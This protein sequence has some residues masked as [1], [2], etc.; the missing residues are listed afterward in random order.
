MR[1]LKKSFTLPTLNVLNSPD[2]GK[3]HEFD[4]VTFLARTVVVRFTGAFLLTAVALVTGFLADGFLVA[5]FPLVIAY[6]IAKCN[7]FSKYLPNIMY[8]N[9]KQ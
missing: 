7:Q 1:R 2:F 9:I 3:S 8:I 5:I 6:I 4:Y